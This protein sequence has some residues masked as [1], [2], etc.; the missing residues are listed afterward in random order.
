MAGRGTFHSN[1]P[2]ATPGDIVN[3]QDALVGAWNQYRITVRSD[4]ITVQLNGTQTARYT[5]ATGGYNPV[6]NRGRFPNDPTF[7]GLQ[8]D[9]AYSDTTAFRNL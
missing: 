5:L 3:P 9:S 8:S 6:P 4:V 1:Q 7:I 2:A